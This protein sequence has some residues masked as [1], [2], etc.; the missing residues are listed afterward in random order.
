MRPMLGTGWDRRVSRVIVCGLRRDGPRAPR[1]STPL[2][3]I[4]L[5]STKLDSGHARDRHS[6]P[7]HEGR[8]DRA[9]TDALRDRPPAGRPTLPCRK[10]ALQL[11]R[12]H[13]L[14]LQPVR[15]RHIRAA[16]VCRLRP[17]GGPSAHPAAND[18]PQT[19]N[20]RPRHQAW[21]RRHRCGVSHS[22]AD[23]A[24]PLIAQPR[25]GCARPR[26]IS[27]PRPRLLT[28]TAFCEATHKRAEA[29]AVS[30]MN[31]PKPTAPSA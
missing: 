21:R 6:R 14:D 5:T 12:A 10:P 4:A 24:S 23:S 11:R 28:A 8:L 31:R 25:C 1:R 19:L 29:R 2:N 16:P 22:V 30:V 7:L 15:T 13:Q 20:I 3:G 9:G 17:P 26:A 27:R 18:H